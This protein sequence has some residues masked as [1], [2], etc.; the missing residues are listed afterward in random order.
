M[1]NE[2][3]PRSHDGFCRVRNCRFLFRGRVLLNVVWFQKGS[4]WCWFGDILLR[5]LQDS[6]G[7][8]F[9]V[10]FEFFLW[11]TGQRIV[12]QCRRRR[13]RRWGM[14]CAFAMVVL[15]L[16][17]SIFFVFNGSLLNFRFHHFSL[18][19]HRIVAGLTCEHGFQR[20]KVIVC[21]CRTF[22]ISVEIVVFIVFIIQQFALASTP[23][24]ER[25]H[26]DASNE[27]DG[28]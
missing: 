28:W 6:R 4:K 16:V 8:R 25:I 14:L 10:C 7:A 19:L 27:D 26:H 23:S 20:C 22:F 9:I 24:H 12:G 15:G 18:V 21:C 11:W 3:A 13:R 17:A 1:N 5:L 2:Y